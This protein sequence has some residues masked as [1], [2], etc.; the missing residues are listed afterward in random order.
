MKQV[1]QSVR[2]GTVRVVDVPRPVIG[3]T[4][5]L[6]AT[7]RTVLSLG[8]ERAAH[9]LASASLV[10]KAR[11]RPDLVRQV[12]RK[13]ASD[14][15]GPTM[16]AVRSRLDQD[17]PMGYSGAG[18]VVEVGETVVGVVPG[19]RVATGGGGKAC[20]ADFQAV[21]A[22]L[23]VPLPEG[24]TFGDGAFATIGAI[25]LHGLRLANV[26]PGARVGVVGLGLLG[27]LATR[28][29]LASGLEVAGIDVRPWAVE[30]AQ[31]S[32]AGLALAE[33]GGD[34][35]AAV[36]D[37]TRGRGLDAVLV[38]AATPSSDPVRRLPA[39]ARDRATVVVVGDVGLDI[40]RRPFYEKELTIQ[41]ARSYGP[42]RYERSYETWGVDYPV[43]HVRWTEGRN[44]EAFLDLIAAGRLRVDDLVTHH[45]PVEEAAAAYE[46]IEASEDGVL[47]VQLEYAPEPDAPAVVTMA[48]RRGGG[49]AVGLLG[50]GNFATMTLVP[51]LREAGFEHLAMVASS[52]GLSARRLAE[53]TGFER[54][55]ASAGLVVSDPDVDV[56]VIATPH[57]THAELVVQ[58][59][60]HGKHVF[61]EKPLALSHDELSAV[62]A[63]WRSHPGH[64][65]VGFNRRHSPAVARVIQH[66]AAAG[67]PLVMTYR[68]NAGALPGD[69]WYHDRRQGGRL[70]G[71]ICHFV[72]TCGALAGGPAT[73][74]HA[75]G[76]G[77]GEAL[78]QEDVVVTVRYGDGSLATISYASGGS[79]ATPKERLEVLG[80]GHTAVV[81]D[82]RRLTLDDKEIRLGGKQDKGHVAE[83][84]AFRRLVRGL[85]GPATLTEPALRSMA[86]TLAA[87][88]S[89][90]T[91]EAVAPRQP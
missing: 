18:T 2:H 1:V 20:H 32:C 42:G 74:V 76:S 29:A 67:G 40:E 11:S 38:T 65:M 85:A 68:V 41:F 22:P 9:G 21:P 10:G 26:G 48:P 36:L 8:T 54:T 7:T 34:T 79:P 83:L 30:R 14:G 47:G 35:T 37:W 58:A 89:L 46:V 87:A 90:L 77:R 88:E 71:E 12:V 63:A 13:A 57:D 15:V 43:G 3:A 84:T 45:F 24:V 66:L 86:T 4:E 27:Q 55:T 44:I 60:E 53:R 28:L 61:C 70:L 78:L 52:S 6:V 23:A 19:Q 33:A 62:V 5:V 17:M 31:E 80:R 56:V 75:A 25:A 82:F 50:A 39:I 16:R 73:Q 72:D 59:L 51:A 69:H 91:G 64:L 81:D 49:E